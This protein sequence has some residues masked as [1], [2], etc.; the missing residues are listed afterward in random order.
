[1]DIEGAEFHV[2]DHLLKTGVFEWLEELF[3][4]WHVDNQWGHDWSAHFTEEQR[5][6][7][8]Q[9]KDRI[10]NHPDVRVHEWD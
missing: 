8:A 4:E 7:Y 1:M 2:L 6:Y 10:C 5:T 3:V 9:L